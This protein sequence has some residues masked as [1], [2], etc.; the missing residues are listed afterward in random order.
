MAE[1]S[2]KEY[3][4]CV[5]LGVLLGPFGAHRFYVGRPLSGAVQCAGSVPLLGWFVWG[6]AT[7][8]LSLERLNLW[9]A[10]LPAVALLAWGL[11]PV[12]DVWLLLRKRF[13]DGQG[14]TVEP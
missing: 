8:D 12:A 14:R 5:S 2:P 9:P 13:H 10:I 1:R 6:Y 4:L 3:G 7:A 11:W